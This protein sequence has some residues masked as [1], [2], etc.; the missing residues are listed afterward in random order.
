MRKFKNLLFAFIFSI[1]LLSINTMEVHA[2]ETGALTSEAGTET[3]DEGGSG[4]D[5]SNPHDKSEEG[6]YW[7][8]GDAI[9]DIMDNQ[10]FAGAIGSIQA[11]TEF[12]DI[13]FTRIITFVAFFIIS[14]A[15]LKNVCAGA[16]CA[17]SKFWDKVAEAHQKSEA[18]TLAGMKD[19]FKNIG[20][21][22]VGGVRDAILGFIPNIK[23]W[24]DFDD[25][26]IE[27]K[28]YFMKAIPQ[29]LACIIIGIFIYNGYYRDTAATVGQMGSE[30]IERTLSSV[31]P[32]SFINKIFNT[33][34]WPDFPTKNDNS[35][36]GQTELAI[37]KELQSLVASEFSD[38]DSTQEKA[39]FVANA[40]KAV[41]D[42]TAEQFERF[43]NVPDAGYSYKIT[44]VKSLATA[45]GVYGDSN[46]PFIL[47]PG[48]E[49]SEGNVP[50]T[51]VVNNPVQTLG[52]ASTKAHDGNSAFVVTGMFKYVAESN[53]KGKSNVDAGGWQGED[54]LNFT[55]RTGAPVTFTTSGDKFSGTVNISS[56]VI[57]FNSG[58]SGGGKVGFDILSC[59]EYTDIP[60]GHFGLNGADSTKVKVDGTWV[61]ISGE[62]SYTLSG[63]TIEIGRLTYN[64]KEIGSLVITPMP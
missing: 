11:I 28:A 1:C 24:T 23:A 58:M 26:D 17:N 43:Y 64:G 16:Y 2:T 14:A 53:G 60:K 5:S 42:N 36:Q 31:N 49:D 55:L 54:E 59:L 22:S 33:T 18:V 25:A 3:G 37:C 15:M 41:R 21:T 50:F 39:A 30:L 57:T 7:G 8:T 34:G 4:S 32:E 52:L 35:L 63:N 56:G 10:R 62:K 46:T 6:I 9:A 40:A 61:V 13:W 44:A 27:P 48:A 12:T 45:A 47:S 38:V 20:N 29:M 51:F 19:A